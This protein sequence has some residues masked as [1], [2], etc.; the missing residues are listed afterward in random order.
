MCMAAEPHQHLM[1]PPARR[2]PPCVLLRL[3][4][5]EEQADCG[6]GEDKAP[7]PDRSVS[8]SFGHSGVLQQAKLGHGEVVGVDQEPVD[9][10]QDHMGQDHQVEPLEGDEVGDAPVVVAG[11]LD[12]GEGATGYL[13]I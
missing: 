7:G 12:G 6:Q 1:V 4:V 13:Q 8:Y 11:W 5:G 10:E 2:L 9:S 3:A